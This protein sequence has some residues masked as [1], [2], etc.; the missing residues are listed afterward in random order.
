MGEGVG[1]R[2]PLALVL[3]LTLPGCLGLGAQDDLTLVCERK[4]GSPWHPYTPD[5][6]KAMTLIEPGATPAG[7]NDATQHVADALLTMRGVPYATFEGHLYPTP[8]ERARTVPPSDWR[9]EGN[10]TT[11]ASVDAYAIAFTSRDGTLVPLEAGVSAPASLVS[12]AEA[13]V[14]QDPEASG[15]VGKAKATGGSWDPGGPS[16]VT[17]AYGEAHRV[18][19]NLVQMRVV[20]AR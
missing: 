7:V 19:V 20:H 1:R 4:A 10:G 18:T 17:L 13:V 6:V 2:V 16:C 14:A 8:D 11:N 12:L 9:F 5:E 3:A 15:L